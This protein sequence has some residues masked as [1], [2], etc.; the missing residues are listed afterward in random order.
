MLLTPKDA[1][2]F[3]ATYEQVALAMHAVAEL[4][5]PGDPKA[6]LA[7]GRKAL[8][9]TPKL[10]GDAV[11]FLNK[12]AIKVDAD[13]VDALRQMQLGEWIHLKDLRS[14]AIFLNQKGTEAYSAA[15]LTQP[16][17]TIIGAR[18]SLVETALCPFA[19]RI[20]C[21]GVFV[22]RLQLGPN[23]WRECHQR[24]L[25]LKAAGQLHRSPAS[26]PLWASAPG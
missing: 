15:G 19:G 3:M 10:L 22:V 14:G 12:E 6:C 26:V 1:R 2:R 4:E 7:S 25:R 5:T 23:I 11:A 9:R 20:H 21:D 17:S 13:V 8:Q 18:G 16:P 24:Y